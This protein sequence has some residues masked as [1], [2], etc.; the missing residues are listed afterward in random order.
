[1]AA[2]HKFAWNNLDRNALMAVSIAVIDRAALTERLSQ[3]S[4]LALNRVSFLLRYIT[5]DAKRWKSG[6]SQDSILQPIFEFGDRVALSSSLILETNVERNI[7]DLVNRTNPQVYDR[8]KDL[9]EADWSSELELV[10]GSH[11]LIAKPQIKYEDTAM[12]VI[13]VDAMHEFA[14]TCELK[15]LL[16]PDRF[17]GSQ[18]DYI[19]NGF[20]Q[21]LRACEWATNNRDAVAEKLTLPR[22]TLQRCEFRP[23]LLCKDTLANGL[24]T[25]GDIPIASGA[26]FDWLVEKRKGN[27]REIWTILNGKKFLPIEGR[28]FQERK[29]KLEFNGITFHVVGLDDASEASNWNPVCNLELREL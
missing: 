12:D 27:I 20:D 11:G 21:A 26:L 3:L 5:C 4:G 6:K 7:L 16:T 22:G 1:M 9:K 24:A 13:I 2:V 28:H 18:I 14:V 15:W 8:V 19:S 23:L 29:S 17:K 10:L 25:H